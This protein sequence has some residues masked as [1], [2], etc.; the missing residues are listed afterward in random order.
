MSSEDA[1]LN[2]VR[3]M[4]D[5]IIR[6]TKARGSCDNADLRCAGCSPCGD[7]S[8]EARGTNVLSVDRR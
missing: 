1:A 3:Y 5:T 8:R 7:R 6:V 4:T 2:T